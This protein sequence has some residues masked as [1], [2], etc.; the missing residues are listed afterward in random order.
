MKRLVS[1]PKSAIISLAIAFVVIGGM[2]PASTQATPLRLWYDYINVLNCDLSGV[3]RYDVPEEE[4]SK[5]VL[6]NEWPS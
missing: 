6:P 3:V 2:V 1:S 4:Y 5:D